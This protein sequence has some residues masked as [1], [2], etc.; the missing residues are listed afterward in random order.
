MSLFFV[1]FSIIDES[2]LLLIALK[3]IRLL[4]LIV[5]LI[6]WKIIIF[7]NSSSDT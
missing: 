7:I 4:A 1:K 5:H 6:N 3:G 2:N